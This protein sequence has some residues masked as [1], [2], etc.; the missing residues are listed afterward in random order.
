MI[1]STNGSIWHLCLRSNLTMLFCLRTI[2]R[3]LFCLSLMRL[4]SILIRINRINLWIVMLLFIL[5]VLC[6][7]TRMWL[8]FLGIWLSGIFILSRKLFRLLIWFIRDIKMTRMWGCLWVSCMLINWELFREGYSLLLHRIMGFLLFPPIGGLIRLVIITVLLLSI[9]FRDLYDF[10]Y[11][12]W[13][14]DSL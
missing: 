3:I 7:V 4:S 11:V 13:A 10:Y 5:L 6:L 9:F 8:L 14:V 1:L 12:D 2:L